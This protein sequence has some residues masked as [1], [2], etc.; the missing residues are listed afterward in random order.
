VTILV[1]GASGFLGIRL[2]RSL[3]KQG[4][5]VIAL[6]RA[7]LPEDA[8]FD[9]A[10]RWVQCDLAQD[11][12]EAEAFPEVE[13]VVHLAGTG[14][15]RG[16]R[17]DQSLD[18]DFFLEGNERTT[19]RL[20]QAF[21]PRVRRFVLASSQVVYGWPDSVSVSEDLPLA[22]TSPYAM[23]KVN[24]E[25]WMRSF[26]ARHGGAYMVLRFCGF[27]EGGGVAD[28]MIDRALGDAPIELFANGTI[29]RDYLSAEDGAR[30]IVLAIDAPMAEGFNP[31]NIGS[32]QALR[33]QE[34][35]VIVREALGSSSAIE[36]IDK[37]SSQGDF[38]FDVKRASEVLGF[39][40]ADLREA[41][42]QYACGRAGKMG[43]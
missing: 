34:M 1:S 36:L 17:V 5:S 13:A 24:G 4:R 9:P 28:Y 14:W 22:G 21:A 12:I 6:H 18:E 41:V 37:P 11:G 32:G 3:A 8:P 40:P 38:V 33:A 31:I 23:S 39:V 2:V 20:L 42:R 35:A 25:G 29:R 27:I 26:Q 7:A 16:A 30:A 10:I 43:K 15:A 19:V